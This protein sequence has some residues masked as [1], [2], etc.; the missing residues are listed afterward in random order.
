MLPNNRP[1]GLCASLLHHESHRSVQFKLGL[2]YFLYFLFPTNAL[3]KLD[4]LSITIVPIIKRK[5]TCVRI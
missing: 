5:K 2:K 3:G 4:L 1:I